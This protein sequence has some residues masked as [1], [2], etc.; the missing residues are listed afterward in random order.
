QQISFLIV[1]LQTV[2]QLAIL[3]INDRVISSTPI[4]YHTF[5]LSGHG[6]VMWLLHGHPDQ[7][8]SELG[9]QRHIFLRLIKPLWRHH[10]TNWRHVNLEDQL[11]I[12][13]Y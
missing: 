13:L 12:F 10:Y 8:Q 3:V 4:P 6:W 5:I 7:N 1:T 11:A 2:I 9:V